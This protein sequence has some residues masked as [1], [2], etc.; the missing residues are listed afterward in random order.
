MSDAGKATGNPF[1]TFSLKLYGRPGVPPACLVLQDEAGVDVNVLL[2]C[3]WVGQCGA[4][5][6]DT[7]MAAVLATT[8]PWRRDVVVPLRGVRRLLK[9]PPPAF[10][11]VGEAFRSKIKA[12][13]L[14]AERLQ[15]EV[16]FAVH[17]M[18]APQPG[19]MQPEAARANA[20]AYGRALGVALPAAALE[21]I[22]TQLATLTP[23]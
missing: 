14:E 16:L 18:L 7:Q 19:A 2:F 21:T 6:S 5:L 3:L 17:G 13:E 15:Q 1:W 23:A 22:L 10:S 4:V 20:L 9:E 8:E 12:V 11:L